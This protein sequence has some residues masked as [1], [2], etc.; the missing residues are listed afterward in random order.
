M[1]ITKSIVELMN[2]TIEVESEKGKG[3]T[4]TVTVTLTRSEHMLMSGEGDEINT[5]DMSVLVVDDDR[6]ACEHAQIILRQVGV[7][8][9]SVLTGREA[10]DMVN[11]RHARR[12]D[13]DLI[14]VD[15]KML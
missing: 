11:M 10:V 15:W 14:I 1:P 6:I 4:F 12:E 2:G 3:T 7:S 9:E 8:C 13:Y 5:H